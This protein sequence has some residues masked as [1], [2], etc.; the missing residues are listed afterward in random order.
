MMNKLSK[1][2]II[3]VIVAMLA[4]CFTACGVT[5]DDPAVTSPGATSSAETELETEL[6]DWL[7]DDLH[8]D[9]DK[10]T[11]ISRY[12]EGWTSGEIAVKEL[13]SE[14][15]NDAVY[16]RNKA[17]EERLGVEIVSIEENNNNPDVVVNK[18]ATAVKAG[19][20]EYRKAVI[21]AM[22]ATDMDCVTGH[23]TYDQ[24]ND[25]EKSAAII[26]IADGK[27]KFWGNY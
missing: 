24:Y 22:K 8:Y 13:L 14:P 3:L 1:L 12:R 7:P 9:G 25:P 27:A 23:V 4:G 6:V 19:T 16:E 5:T 10:I 17:V 21:A 15:V 20:D 11:V 26:T 2:L 18:V